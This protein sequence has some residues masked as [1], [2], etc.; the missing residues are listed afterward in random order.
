MGSAD[1]VI[2]LATTVAER[3]GVAAFA[4]SART[5]D[6]LLMMDAQGRY[7]R[8]AK[9]RLGGVGPGAPLAQSSQT[10]VP[11]AA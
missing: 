8:I 1:A 2:G 4:A 9:L 3:G 10:A 7:L 5:A 11:G 6:P